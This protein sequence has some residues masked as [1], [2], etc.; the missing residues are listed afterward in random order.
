MTI[1]VL[2]KFN[3]AEG[4]WIR[5]KSSGRLD[6]RL[7]VKQGLGSSQLDIGAIKVSHILSK[8]YLGLL[9]INFSFTLLGNTSKL[10]TKLDY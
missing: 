5:N 8:F 1:D 4:D 7:Q 3:I 10:T 9:N 6:Y 2:E